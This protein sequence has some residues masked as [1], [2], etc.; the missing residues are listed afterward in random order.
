MRSH[1][2]FFTNPLLEPWRRERSA[3]SFAA[4]RSDVPVP[5][6]YTRGR[7]AC[8]RGRKSSPPNAGVYGDRHAGSGRTRAP[9]S[10]WVVSALSF[11]PRAPCRIRAIFARPRIA[12]KYLF[13]KRVYGLPVS[14]ESMY[15]TVETRTRDTKIVELFMAH[16][17]NAVDLSCRR[18]GGFSVLRGTQTRAQQDGTFLLEASSLILTARGRVAELPMLHRKPVWEMRSASV[19]AERRGHTCDA[20]F[21]KSV[22]DPQR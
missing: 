16:C 22:S 17:A 11:L 21:G 8:R 3:I 2:F 10:Y 14:E 6:R 19:R 18:K 15:K 1:G 7:S 13:S 12:D 20:L 5:G 4:R 9:V